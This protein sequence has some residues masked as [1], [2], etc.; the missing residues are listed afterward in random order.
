MAGRVCVV[1]GGNA[2]IGK[3]T[4]IGLAQRGARV[5]L[6][7]RTAERGEPALAEVRT[8]C[9]AADVD[10][11]LGDLTTQAS[12]RALADAL[13]AA[14]PTLHVLVNNA[15]LW[16]TERTV[17]PDGFETTFA[18][19]HLGP[20]LLTHLLLDRLRASGAARIVN[21]SSEGHRMGKIRF[22]DLQ[23]ERHFDRVRT[24]CDSKLCNVLF[25]RRLARELAGTDV[26]THAV[27]PGVVRSDLGRRSSGLVRLG[28]ALGR[29]FFKTAEQGA[30][31]SIYVASAPLGM[32]NGL[33]FKDSKPCAPAKAALDD[34][35]ADRLWDVSL[36]MTGLA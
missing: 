2:G 13:L 15:G 21:L 18:V 5:V 29:P 19:N 24:Y 4:V 35:V 32:E 6:V 31:T 22:D 17:T 11:V 14:C 36:G 8:A 27:H 10:L 26:I 25:T 28:F 3:A 20:F 12:V 16:M 9:P 23:A 1:T 7:S 34:A 30:R 33:Y